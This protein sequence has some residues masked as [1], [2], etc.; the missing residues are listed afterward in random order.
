MNKDKIRE[1]LAAIKEEGG[2]YESSIIANNEISGT[3]VDIIKGVWVNKKSKQKVGFFDI[4]LKSKGEY[5]Q[6]RHWSSAKKLN[7]SIGDTI[8]IFVTS[9]NSIATFQIVTRAKKDRSIYPKR[10]TIGNIEIFVRDEEDEK[11][12]K[13]ELLER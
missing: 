12:I 13:K 5:L 2:S 4:V 1:R 3:V 8:K 6:R 10:L 11:S 9:K 7:M